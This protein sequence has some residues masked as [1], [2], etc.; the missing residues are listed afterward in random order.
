M[1]KLALA[2]VITS[3][4]L[5]PY[6]YSHIIG[7]LINYPPRQIL[8]KL[9]TLDHLLEWAIELSQFDIKFKP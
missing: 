7:V 4:K 2:L 9:D 6:F 1:E 8:Q 5:R 3:Q